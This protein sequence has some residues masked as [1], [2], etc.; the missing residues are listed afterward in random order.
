MRLRPYDLRLAPLAVALILVTTAVPIELRG[1]AAWSLDVG[2]QDIIQNLLLYAP[3]GVALWARPTWRVFALAGALSLCIEAAQLWQ[4]GRFASPVDLAAN[5]LGAVAG[6]LLYRRRPLERRQS[7]VDVRVTGARLTFALVPAL[8][9]LADWATRARPSDLSN[10]DP[11]YPLLI[12]NESM[13]VRPW[14]GEISLLR[15]GSSAA[16]GEPTPAPDYAW[17]ERTLLRG[18]PALVLPSEASSRFAHSAMAGGAFSVRLRLSTDDVDEEGPARIVSFSADTLH[19]NFDLGQQGD[20]LVFRV[21][22]PVTGLNGQ[23]FRVTSA[24]VLA[25]GLPVDVEASYDGGIARI[26][27]DGVLS[28]RS[29]IAAAGCRASAFCDW[30]APPAWA[31]LGA[32]L[33]M[34]ALAVLPLGSSRALWF[35]VLAAGAVAVGL[36]SPLPLYSLVAGASRLLPLLAFFGAASVGVARVRATA[37]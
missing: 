1:G 12:G 37:S 28:G 16:F 4:A 19:R 2:T 21:R 26:H 33:V 34:L 15:I 3:L 31:L 36:V 18:G 20:R 11:S 10:W 6:A 13:P 9:V 25:V 7:P 35:T 14:R 5:T 29:N 8:L 30:A 27:V 24:P 22:T 17:A 23:R 32:A